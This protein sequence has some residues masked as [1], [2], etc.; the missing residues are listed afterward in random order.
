MVF[1][2]YPS[3]AKKTFFQSTIKSRSNSMF[4][5]C[6]L[7]YYLINEVQERTNIAS[8]DTFN[9]EHIFTRVITFRYS[10]KYV[11]ST[12]RIKDSFEMSDNF[13]LVENKTTFEFSV[14]VY[15]YVLYYNMCMTKIIRT[16]ACLMGPTSRL[17]YWLDFHILHNITTN[18]SVN[19]YRYYGMKSV[20]MILVLLV[21]EKVFRQ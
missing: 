18:W 5:E 15:V 12:Y 19:M 21:L 2:F 11:L 6:T 1:L 20:K 8:T 14:G 9:L 3:I 16:C 17:K 13:N 4:I 7:Q 10:S